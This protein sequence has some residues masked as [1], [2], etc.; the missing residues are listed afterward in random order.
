MSSEENIRVSKEEL[1]N[2]LSNVIMR[3]TNYSKE[4]AIQK[5]EEY[6]YNVKQILLD[7]YGIKE[8]TKETKKT[9]E[10]YDLIR[11]FLDQS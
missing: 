1:D 6:K 5:L 3:Q 2:K 8:E 9:E 4:E 10:R 7:Y 11:T